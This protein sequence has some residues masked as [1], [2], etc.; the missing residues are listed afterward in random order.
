MSEYWL[1]RTCSGQPNGASDSISGDQMGVSGGERYFHLSCYVYLRGIVM[2][3]I[4]LKLDDDLAKKAMAY[5]G[6]LKLKRAAYIRNAIQHYNRMIEQESLSQRL[7]R[8]SRACR[9]ESRTVNRAIRGAT[10]P[11]D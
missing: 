8:A 7:A 4:H 10:Y 3:F 11:W 2:A 6:K 1:E 9:Q 5:A